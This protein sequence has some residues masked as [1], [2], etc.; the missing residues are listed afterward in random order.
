MVHSEMLELTAGCDMLV[1]CCSFVAAL[2]WLSGLLVGHLHAWTMD[3]LGPSSLMAQVL[4]GPCS[5]GQSDMNIRTVYL[6]MSSLLLSDP[7]CFKEYLIGQVC[8]IG[9][10][11]TARQC[12]RFFS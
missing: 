4:W 8:V 1:G 2:G 7:K 3:S 5:L 6:K 11:Q 12:S 9:V 10:S